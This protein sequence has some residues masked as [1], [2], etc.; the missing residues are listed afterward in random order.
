M[1]SLY[2][3][4]EL[5]DH[6]TQL[7][8][9]FAI[10]MQVTQKLGDVINHVT[11]KLGDMIKHVKLKLGEV[12]YHVTLKLGNMIDWTRDNFQNNL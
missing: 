9:E 4:R 10:I 7:Q 11:R 12:M 3:Q 1:L 6:V 8:S 2:F 5:I